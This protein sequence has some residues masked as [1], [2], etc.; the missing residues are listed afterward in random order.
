MKKNVKPLPFYTALLGLILLMSGPTQ[1][2][3][4]VVLH[5]SLDRLGARL[6]RMNPYLYRPAPPPDYRRD[7]RRDYYE[8]GYEDGRR[9]AEYYNS[10][11]ERP[12][13][14][15]PYYEAPQYEN[16]DYGNQYEELSAE[17]QFVRRIPRGAEK[18]KMAGKP[19]YM[20]EGVFYK[21]V[22]KGYIIIPPPIGLR[23]K[24]VPPHSL[25]LQIDGLTYYEINDTWYL[26]VPRK[27]YF[28]IV[29]PPVSNSRK[30]QIQDER[31]RRRNSKYR[32]W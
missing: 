5:F 4:Q 17:G 6:S 14:D 19:F 16:N 24:H 12:Y 11:R 23:V 15:E 13:Y 1:L 22:K 2:S 10:R 25:R 28:E 32:R 27:R 18:F 9:D 21:P 20:N 7:Y 26:D 8:D 3:A 30:N 31:E 29:T